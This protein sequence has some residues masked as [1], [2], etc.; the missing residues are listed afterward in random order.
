MR[1]KKSERL[2][3]RILQADFND[4]EKIS[5][6]YKQVLD[7]YRDKLPEELIIS[8]QP[9]PTEVKERLDR[10]THFVAKIENQIIG[11]VGCSL[12]HGTCML[13]HMVVDQKYQRRGVG[14]ALTRQVINFAQKHNAT[15]VWLDT[16]PD[17]TGAISLYQKL[18]FQKSGIL[19]QHFWGVDVE[20][21]ELILTNNKD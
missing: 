10:Y 21:Y 17:L 8:R 9:S 1:E 19:R 2:G 7:D 13:K 6:L 20:L 5:A 12:I 15:K 16:V 3:F 18:G 4:I 11:V 14:T